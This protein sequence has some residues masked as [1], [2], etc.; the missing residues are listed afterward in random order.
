M[1][2]VKFLEIH[3]LFTKVLTDVNQDPCL[4][5]GKEVGIEEISEHLT[6]AHNVDPDVLVALEIAHGAWR[7]KDYSLH[8]V[9]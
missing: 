9:S 6:S 1:D 5:R 3:A 4:P 2:F 8:S 7:R